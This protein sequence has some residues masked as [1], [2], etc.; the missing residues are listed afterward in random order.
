MAFSR[1]SLT[2]IPGITQEQID[3]IMTLHGTSLSDYVTKS[4]AEAAQQQAIADALAKAPK[5]NGAETEEYKS[6]Q[7]QFDQYKLSQSLTGEYGVKGKFAET[8]AGMLDSTKDT[9]EQIE[10]LRTEYEE[11]FTPTEQPKKTP[12]FS[13]EPGANNVNPTSEE[14]KLLAEALEGFNK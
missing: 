14:D 4:D 8:V 11:Y 6:L 9:K 5:P 13:K 2:A 12:V 3:A 7:K 10:A 1:K